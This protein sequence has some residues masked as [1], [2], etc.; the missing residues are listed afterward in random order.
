MA[1]SS[2]HTHL[3]LGVCVPMILPFGLCDYR[4]KLLSGIF[5]VAQCGAAVSEPVEDEH[6]AMLRSKVQRRYVERGV[7]GFPGALLKNNGCEE[8]QLVLL[9]VR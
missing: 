9:T 3:I 2:V 4:L 1:L 8:R 5:E 7:S 6:A